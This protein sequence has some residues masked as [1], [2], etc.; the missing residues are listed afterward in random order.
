MYYHTKNNR[1]GHGQSIWDIRVLL[2]WDSTNF[3]PKKVFDQ[4]T[5]LIIFSNGS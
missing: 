5:K 2:D 1:Y 4:K 3:R